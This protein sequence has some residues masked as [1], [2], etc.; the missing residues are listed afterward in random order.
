MINICLFSILIKPTIDM[1]MV[2]MLAFQVGQIS[3]I[4]QFI[5]I[6]AQMIT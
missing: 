1:H 6:A 2:S 4:S 5:D 3:Y